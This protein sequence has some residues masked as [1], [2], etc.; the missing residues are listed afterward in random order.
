MTR[1]DI[2]NRIAI[3]KHGRHFNEIFAIKSRAEILQQALDEVLEQV[4]DNAVLHSVVGSTC[5]Y[6]GE[7]TVFDNFCKPCNKIN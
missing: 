4:N 3:K 5:L 2:L 7:L 1:D 6:C